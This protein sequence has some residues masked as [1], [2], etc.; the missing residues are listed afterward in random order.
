MKHRVGSSIIW[1]AILPVVILVAGGSS[2]AASSSYIDCYRLGPKA[3]GCVETVDH[4]QNLTVVSKDLKPLKAE[5]Q[6]GFIQ[7]TLQRGMATATRD[8][9]WDL[10]YLLDTSHS[11]PKQL[12]P[13]RTELQ[14]AGQ[15][16]TANY[17]YATTRIKRMADPRLAT[18]YKRQIFRLLGIYHGTRFDQPQD[19][20]FSGKWLPEVSTFAPS[21][22]LLG[23]GTARVSFLDVYYVNAYYDLGDMIS[24]SSGKKETSPLSKCS[25][26]VKRTDDKD[27]IIAH[28]TWMGFL[29]MSMAMNIFVNDDFF[30]V[31]AQTPLLITSTTDFGFNNKG[32]LYN[33]TT[34]HQTYS[35]PKVSA[36]WMFLRAAVAEQFASSIDE[37]FDYI[38]IEPSGTY[39]NGY[40]VVDSKTKQFG[41]V[42]M[43]YK[44]F[45]FFHPREG[46]GYTVTTKPS[47]LSKGYDAGLL[48]ADY[49]LGINYPVSFQIREDLQAQDTR[50]ARRVQLRQR[51]GGRTGHPRSEG[52]HHL[53][54]SR[55]PPVHLW[56]LGPGI[57]RNPHATDHPRRGHRR[58]GSEGVRDCPGHEAQRGA[59]HQLDRQ[60]LLD[61]VRD[62]LRGRPALHLEPVSVERPETQGHSGHRGWRLSLLESSFEMTVKHPERR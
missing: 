42:E 39:M 5:Y 14:K 26:F 24:F 62:A 59:E 51:I 28:N 4:I 19:L 56:S 33:E 31:N 44:S 20:D 12:P 53:H 54:R 36:L 1:M 30:S 61:E 9:L 41:L 34:H 25:A 40:M 38:S 13:S 21:E 23:Y 32:L 10:L 46:G 17:L 55:E 58:Q 45:V 52:P 43:S 6:A 15:L 29:D 47:G 49:M 3:Q 16:L 35:R 11:F 22:F 48:A 27:V 57:R 37:F 60:E 2:G 7:G 18:M 50:P 8:N